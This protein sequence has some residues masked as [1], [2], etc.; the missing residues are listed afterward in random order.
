MP[1]QSEVTHGTGA[2]Q[3]DRRSPAIADTIA[4]S[5]PT[6]DDCDL[7]SQTGILAIF[8]ARFRQLPLHRLG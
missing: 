3:Q 8:H 6:A 4:R 2:R 7:A 1:C 5:T